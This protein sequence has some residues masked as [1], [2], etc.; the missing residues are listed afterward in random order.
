M[1][2][3]L[4]LQHRLELAKSKSPVDDAVNAIAWAHCMAGLPSP[5]DN[6]LVQALV[7]G[8]HRLVAKPAV[9]K[10]PVTVEMLRK[11]VHRFAGPAATLSDIHT[12][13]ICLLGFS[14][15]LRFDELSQVRA[16]DLVFSKELLNVNIRSSK[17]D[18][19]RQ[20][21]QVVVSR[22]AKVTCPVAMLERYLQGQCHQ[23][24]HCF[25]ES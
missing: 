20:G 22:S 19:F 3:A 1:H 11:L 15:F 25:V 8:A 6:P 12:V 14:A 5:T 10:E 24:S 21:N 7:A 2:V 23:I 4:Y 13:S 9:K 17:T 18:Q 16:S